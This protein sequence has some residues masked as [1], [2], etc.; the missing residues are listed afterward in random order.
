LSRSDHPIPVASSVL[1]N[2][3]GE[4]LMGLRSDCYLWEIPGGKVGNE[5]YAEAARREL[6]EETG[7]VAQGEPFLVGISEE[8]G[9]AEE[10]REQ[11]YILF[12]LAWANWEGFPQRIEPEKCLEWWWMPVTGLPNLADCTNGTASFIQSVLPFMVGAMNEAA[13]VGEFARRDCRE[14]AEQGGNRGA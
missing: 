5:S 7:I 9:N 11:R 4:L 13:F 3:R 12:Y 1:I 2:Q 10:F 14:L 6:R 8:F